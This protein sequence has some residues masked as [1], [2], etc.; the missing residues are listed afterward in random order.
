MQSAVFPPLKRLAEE[1]YGWTS[2]IKPQFRGKGLGKKLFE[3]IENSDEYEFIRL[4]VEKENGRAMKLY[5]SLGY[6]DAEY[7]SLYKKT[8]GKINTL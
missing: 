7:L 1:F 4:E 5:L 6:K 8:K 3:F 2:C